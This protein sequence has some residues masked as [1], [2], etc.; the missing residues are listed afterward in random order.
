MINDLVLELIQLI[1]TSLYDINAISH[2]LGI[3]MEDMVE[4]FK[5]YFIE[6]RELISELK[7][8]FEKND[9]DKL[10]KT[11]HNIKG[12]SSNLKI[13]DIYNTALKLDSIISSGKADKILSCIINLEKM[14][15]Y[16][17]LE[18]SDFFKKHGFQ[19]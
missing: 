11:N 3:D 13:H 15:E 14:A 8:L 17:Q 7:D 5:V 9:W 1:D 6:I 16:S 4:I 2:E 12:I 19:I 10:Q 18:I